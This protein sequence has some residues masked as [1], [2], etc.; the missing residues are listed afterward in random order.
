MKAYYYTYVAILCFECIFGLSAASPA[1]GQRKQQEP[2]PVKCVD[3]TT[4]VRASGFGY[5]HIVHLKN[6]CNAAQHCD[7]TA[8]SNPQKQSVELAPKA[9]SDVIV[10]INSPA[11]EFTADVA[12]RPAS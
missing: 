6:Q 10:H 5:K 7:V 11:R 8:S 3:W 4:E 1:M 12:C 9:S 2:P